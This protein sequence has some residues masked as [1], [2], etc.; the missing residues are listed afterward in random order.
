MIRILNL[1][2]N[3]TE[4]RYKVVQRIFYFFILFDFLGGALAN[5][6]GAVNGAVAV[7]GSGPVGGGGGC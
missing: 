6:I 7:R 3:I 5:V 4:F 2:I 1:F